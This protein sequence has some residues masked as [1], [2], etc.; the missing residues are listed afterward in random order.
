MASTLTFTAK[1]VFGNQRV[2]MG[3]MT[4]TDGTDEVA[5]GLKYINYGAA[6]PSVVTGAETRSN[7]V[8]NSTTDGTV[9]LTTGIS[10]GVYNV[11]LIGR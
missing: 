5:S 6:T 2:W 9:K 3:T 7:F 8:V 10:A 11:L 1:T 4:A